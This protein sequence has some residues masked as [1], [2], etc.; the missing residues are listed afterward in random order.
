[1]K[2]KAKMKKAEEE[3]DLEVLQQ[4][5]ATLESEMK[6]KMEEIQNKWDLETKDVIET[7]VK[8][9][10]TDVKVE[11]LILAWHPYW[12]NKKGEKTSALK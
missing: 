6:D 5:Y 11:N 2:R 1:M 4:K 12:K 9:R 8:P 3:E 7:E 10:R